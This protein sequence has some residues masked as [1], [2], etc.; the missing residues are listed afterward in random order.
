M[1]T[2]ITFKLD[3][4]GIAELLKGPEISGAIDAAGQQVAALAGGDAKAATTD[5]HISIVRVEAERQARDGAL[6][7][8]AAACGLEV[9]AKRS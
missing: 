3:H 8:A 6:T 5:R 1:G 2:K 4:A 9:K 7:R